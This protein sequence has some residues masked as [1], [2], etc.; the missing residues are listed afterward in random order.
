MRNIP[1]LSSDPRDTGHIYML[2]K[3]RHLIFEKFDIPKAEVPKSKDEQVRML[4]VLKT[5][6]PDKYNEFYNY[7]MRDILPEPEVVTKHEPIPDEWI[8]PA[9]EKLQKH[10]DDLKIEVSTLN[11]QLT[12]TLG[13]GLEQIINNSTEK[14]EILRNDVDARIKKAVEEVKIVEHKIVVKDQAGNAKR[15]IDSISHEALQDVIDLAVNRVNILLVGPAG[16]GKTHLASMAAKALDMEY[17]GQSCSA[18][19]SESSFSGWLLP[20]E[21]SGQF[22]Y[23]QSEFVRMYE[24]GGLF[25][26]D[27]MDAADANTMLF[28]NQ[29]LANSEFFLPQRYENPL[30]KRH[31]DFVA[32]G[33]ANTFG[34]GATAMYSGRNIMDGA[35]MDR[36]RMG[37][38]PMDY[39]AQ[40]EEKLIHEHILKMGRFFRLFIEKRNIRKIMSTRF[41]IEATKMYNSGW[42]IEKIFDT[43]LS[44]W[45]IEERKTICSDRT[46]GNCIKNCKNSQ[47]PTSKGDRWEAY[48]EDLVIGG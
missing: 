18:G 41:L 44:D 2:A 34:S 45:S 48:D 27:E 7:I 4:T 6:D 10:A 21:K 19:M 20:I 11:A 33:A 17:A 5:E 15:K 29:A 12:E 31:K 47:K 14:M 26:F 38:I 9:K 13:T 25:L 1:P 16:C 23:V 22:V 3:H 28:L 43:Y 36:F 30:V 8:D 32:I 46:F 35:T 40:V 39:S 24:N 42:T 37:I